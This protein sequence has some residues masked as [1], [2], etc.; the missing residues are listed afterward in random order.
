M[1]I[2]EV[3]L[4]SLGGSIQVLILDETSEQWQVWRAF[5]RVLGSKDDV[6]LKLYTTLLEEKRKLQSTDLVKLSNKSRYTINMN[7]KNLMTIGLV[8]CDYL[9]REPI[10]VRSWY[11]EKHVLGLMR[12][13]PAEYFNEEIP[14]KMVKVTES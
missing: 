6:A 9:R 3:Y 8:G 2:E 10:E 5:H 13:I 4:K 11:P 14:K 7:M 1:L 12:L